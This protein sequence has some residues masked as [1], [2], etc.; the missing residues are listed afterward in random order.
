MKKSTD[1]AQR[2]PPAQNDQQELSHRFTSMPKQATL[3]PVGRRQTRL[4]RDQRAPV[5]TPPRPSSPKRKPRPT[6]SKQASW[7]ISRLFR[8]SGAAYRRSCS[9]AVCSPH[10]QGQEGE[11]RRRRRTKGKNGEGNRRVDT[12]TLLYRGTGIASTFPPEIVKHDIFHHATGTT[13]VGRG[14]GGHHIRWFN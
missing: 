12:A 7:C 9:G 10:V 5:R 11:K 8:V 14:G 6:R 2:L 1:K 4:R 13:A 3:M